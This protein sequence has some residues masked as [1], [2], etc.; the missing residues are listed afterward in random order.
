[1]TIVLS[2]AMLVG[3]LNCIKIIS[4]TRAGIIPVSKTKCNT[5]ISFD[6]LHE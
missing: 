6:F 2:L 4:N 5:I 3:I 1:M